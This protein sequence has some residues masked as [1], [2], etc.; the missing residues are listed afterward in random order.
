M[1][2][3]FIQIPS[4]GLTQRELE[5]VVQSHRAFV[6]AIDASYEE[7]RLVRCINGEVVSESESD[8]PE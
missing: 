7:Q 6:S 4:L 5:L 3:F 1:M 2:E 8:N